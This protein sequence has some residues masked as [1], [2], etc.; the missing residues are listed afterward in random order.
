[1]EE[2]QTPRLSPRLRN[3]LIADLLENADPADGDRLL[4][5]SR[6]DERTATDHL[7]RQL[8]F[9]TPCNTDL[10]DTLVVILPEIDRM[11]REWPL[12]RD[13]KACGELAAVATK[14]LR[15]VETYAALLA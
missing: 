13:G 9:R 14:S 10:H 8:G 5:E 2:V 15:P 7:G 12:P 1:M 3:A 4:L 11:L 6:W